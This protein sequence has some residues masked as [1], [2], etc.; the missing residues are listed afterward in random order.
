M[1]RLRRALSRIGVRLM[2][3]NVLLVFLPLGAVVTLDRTEQQLLAAQER[4]MVQ[5]GRLVAAALADAEPGEIVGSVRRAEAL[6]LLWRLRRE[7]TARIRVL[8]RDGIVLA[9]SA[10]FGPRRD[11][12][13]D[14]VGAGAGAP[15]GDGGSD[16]LRD[17][18]LYRVGALPFR[19]WQEI[20]GRLGS[21]LPGAAAPVAADPRSSPA[22]GE[23]ETGGL[24]PEVQAALS[25]RYG[26]ASRRLPGERWTTLHSA[27]PIRA[28]PRLQ[29]LVS[30]G[31]PSGVAGRVPLAGIEPEGGEVIGAVLLSQSTAQ[32]LADLDAAR[33]AVGRVIV[34]S[35]FVAALLS[36][37]MAGTIARPLRRLR[38]DAEGLL[39]AGGRLVGEIESPRRWDEIGDLRDALRALAR[40]LRGQQEVAESFAADVAHEIKTPLAAIR[41]ASEVL[42]SAESVEQRRRFTELIHAN[43]ARAEQLLSSLRELAAIDAGLEEDRVRV[44]LAGVGSLPG[45]D[46]AR[47]VGELVENRRAAGDAVRYEGPESGIVV[48]GRPERLEQV[49]DNLVENA[50]SFHPA[51][52]GDVEVRLSHDRA[53]GD[54]VLRVSDRGPGIPAAD[55]EKVF[56]RF[57]S[58]RP[59]GSEKRAGD[60]SHAGL[61]LAIVR[62]VVEAYGGSV[63]ARN[64]A[65]GG[66]VF[67]CR[68][69]SME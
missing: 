3:F 9:D 27:L 53:D 59:A 44:E 69:Q 17:R 11:E 48:R 57:Y 68:L 62:S 50:L 15:P 6:G 8:D 7:T 26:A 34:V 1:K 43:V 40:R 18:L 12:T 37:W 2:A 38:A 51:M 30:T 64:A 13:R 52:A 36:L 67:E 21:F 33:L 42:Q 56:R 14:G 29:V 20:R 47:L 32:V 22:G 31:A 19:A 5:Q 39:D 4:A 54:V 45:C 55:L 10:A 65:G 23:L 58:Y 49:I 24:G 41:S 66:A 46:L 61:G 16:Q 35:L 28:A 60:H 63:V 25:G